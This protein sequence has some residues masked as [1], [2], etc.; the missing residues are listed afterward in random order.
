MHLATTSLSKSFANKLTVSKFSCSVR[1]AF[2]Y[3]SIL[4]GE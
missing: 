2:P 3:E 4:S 1:I